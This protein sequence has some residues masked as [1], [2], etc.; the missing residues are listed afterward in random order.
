MEKSFIEYNLENLEKMALIW[1]FYTQKI[2]T[3]Y[4]VLFKLLF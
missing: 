2:I 4:D 3:L 1:V